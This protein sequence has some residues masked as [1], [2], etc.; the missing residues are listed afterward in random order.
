MRGRVSCGSS[1]QKLKV[2]SAR[3]ADS[4]GNFPRTRAHARVGLNSDAS[5][6]FLFPLLCVGELTYVLKLFFSICFFFWP[7]LCNVVIFIYTYIQVGFIWDCF[8]FIYLFYIE[9]VFFFFFF[10]TTSRVSS[11]LTPCL[12]NVVLFSQQLIKKRA[13]KTV[14][15]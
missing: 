7:T 2:F 1:T 11:A 6:Y 4:A 3:D 14:C 5:F 15:F 13:K 9:K 12:Q 8:I 10:L